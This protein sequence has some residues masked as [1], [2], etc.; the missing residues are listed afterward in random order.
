VLNLWAGMSE[1]I[2][3]IPLA[4]EYMYDEMRK[5]YNSI[6]KD[7]GGKGTTGQWYSKRCRVHFEQEPDPDNRV[8]LI[9]DR[10]W[11]GTQKVK[12]TIKYSDLQKRT[13]VESMKA[14]GKA[15]GESFM[16][17]VRVSTDNTEIF[18]SFAAGV[19]GHHHGTTRM[20]DDP[21]LGTVN[22]DCQSHSVNN[23]FIAGASVFP[24]SSSENPTYTI[25]AMS[26]R[27]ADHLKNILKG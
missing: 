9:E 16:G 26:I 14:I 23:L 22:S 1:F 27:L 4:P 21:K 12:V 8:S 11:L 19:G 15:L 10:D 7:I 3:S 5:E 20:S 24:T 17:K 6:S 25:I 2:N 13:I 18:N